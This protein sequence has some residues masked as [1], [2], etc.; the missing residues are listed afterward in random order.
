MSFYLSAPI[1][2]IISVSFLSMWLRATTSAGYA[3]RVVKISIV[4]FG[5]LVVIMIK[6]SGESLQMLWTS[7][8]SKI[9]LPRKVEEKQI[10][11]MPEG[12][13]SLAN[14]EMPPTGFAA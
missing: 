3:T 9:Y 7:I 11:E 12:F 6:H 5:A 8:S 13:V 4:L 10:L 1:A 14:R 2:I